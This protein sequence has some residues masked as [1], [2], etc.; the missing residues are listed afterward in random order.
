MN[1]HSV[2]FRIGCVF[3]LRGLSTQ[4]GQPKKIRVCLQLDIVRTNEYVIQFGCALIF[5]LG[6][7]TRCDRSWFQ[8]STSIEYNCV[9]FVLNDIYAARSGHYRT[10][11]R[12]RVDLEWP[13]DKRIATACV[14]CSHCFHSGRPSEKKTEPKNTAYE[15]VSPRLRCCHQ[16][17]FNLF[18]ETK[19]WICWQQILAPSRT[20]EKKKTTTAHRQLNHGNFSEHLKTHAIYRRRMTAIFPRLWSCRTR[21][22]TKCISFDCNGGS[23][24]STVPSFTVG[25]IGRIMP[26]S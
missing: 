23:A 13:F 20:N 10:T 11:D 15:W 5:P 6:L 1:G 4:C 2:E 16:I 17:T 8:F 22:I 7:F 3:A 12:R 24:S 14:R 19:I 26:P 9:H 25:A 21:H 18:R